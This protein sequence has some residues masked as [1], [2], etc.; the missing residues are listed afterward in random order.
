MFHLTSTTW[1]NQCSPLL[2]HHGPGGADSTRL[3]QVW[4]SRESN[5][6]GYK[7][8]FWDVAI[9]PSLGCWW[10]PGQT[11]LRM[12]MGLERLGPKLPTSKLVCLRTMPTQGK[13]DRDRE[14]GMTALLELQNPAVPPLIHEPGNPWFIF[15]RLWWFLSHTTWSPQEHT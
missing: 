15:H 5:T 3:R 9:K 6:F 11:L 14:R 7:N 13:Q 1:G 4:P 2:S 12:L 10:D 8:E